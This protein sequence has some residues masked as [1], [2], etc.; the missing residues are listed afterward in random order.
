VSSYKRRQQIGADD[1]SPQALAYITEYV[2]LNM[3]PITSGQMIGAAQYARQVESIGTLL[4]VVSSAADT[5]I[6]S[7]T[8]GGGTLATDGCVRALILGDYLNNSGAGR[9]YQL[10][11]SFGATT[12]YLDTSSSL[13]A[14]ANRRPMII[15]LY[16][17]AADSP[18]AQ[19]L[20]GWVT[21]GNSGGATTGTGD[22][23]GQADR[24][25]LGGEATEDSSVNKAFTVKWQH[26][27]SSASLSFKRKYVLLTK[28]GH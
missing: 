2:G 8:L 27:A 20:T 18:S 15:D 21:L 16:L 28:I 14:S 1:L 12:M 3:P 19:T 17:S 5:T 7:F 4:E 24:H 22:L 10:T 25:A 13:T 23:S 26:S 11:V 9:T 6:Y